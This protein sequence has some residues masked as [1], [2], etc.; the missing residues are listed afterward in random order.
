M[1]FNSGFKGLI[2]RGNGSFCHQ[3][4]N[5]GAVLNKCVAR[6]DK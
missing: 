2:H 1:E 4:G 5:T 6:K 3:P